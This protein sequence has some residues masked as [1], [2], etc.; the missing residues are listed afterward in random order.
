MSELYLVAACHSLLRKHRLLGL[1]L[2][3]VV[4]ICARRSTLAVSGAKLVKCFSANEPAFH[5]LL[6]LGLETLLR[7]HAFEIQLGRHG[8][9]LDFRRSNARSKHEALLVLLPILSLEQYLGLG[10]D[11][12]HYSR[13]DLSR[14]IPL[15][16]F[17]RLRCKAQLG[18]HATNAVSSRVHA[19]LGGTEASLVTLEC[20][21]VGPPH[22]ASVTLFVYYVIA[23]HEALL[24]VLHGLHALV[25]DGQANPILLLPQLKHLTRVN[26]SAVRQDD[27]VLLYSRLLY[28]GRLRVEGGRA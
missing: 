7:R 23:Y 5:M 10:V 13:V 15:E 25:E 14:R 16:R 20:V 9:L 26:F 19:G 3:F 4:F 11:V 2:L 21:P 6:Q 12:A 27:A 8:D 22:F 24:V 18:V 1:L 28:V 17:T